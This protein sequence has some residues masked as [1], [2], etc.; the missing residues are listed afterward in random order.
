M[1]HSQFKKA[2]CTYNYV[3]NCKSVVRPCYECPSMFIVMLLSVIVCISYDNNDPFAPLFIPLHHF[4]VFDEVRSG[5]MSTQRIIR[6]IVSSLRV[7][8]L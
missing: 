5:S 6:H 2:Y 7:R 4:V 3:E 8:V 1:G